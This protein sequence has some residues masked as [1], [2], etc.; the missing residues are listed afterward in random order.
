[1]T[2]YAHTPCRA[3]DDDAS[4]IARDLQSTSTTAVYYGTSTVPTTV[5][6]HAWTAA[7]GCA[8]AEQS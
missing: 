5:A 2:Q 6:G 1:M 7:D 3:T 8:T 4:A